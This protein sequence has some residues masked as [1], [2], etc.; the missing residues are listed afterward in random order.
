MLFTKST[1]YINYDAIFLLLII[2]ILLASLW[3]DILGK[4]IN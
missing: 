3:E 4:L 2:S 1:E